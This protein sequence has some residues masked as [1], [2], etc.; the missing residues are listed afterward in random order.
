MYPKDW[1]AHFSSINQEMERLLDHLGGS[2]PP[3]AR[4]CPSMVELA[5][6]VYETMEEVV[7]VMELAGLQA[8]DDVELIVEGASLSIRGQRKDPRMGAPRTYHSMEICYGPFDRSLVLPT[9]V[10]ADGASVSYRDGL[11]EITLPKS[12]QA[13]ARRIPIKAR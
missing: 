11:L 7:V 1:T 8:E 9:T 2:K 10:D 13:K 3:A 6:D 5:V 4:F 12:P